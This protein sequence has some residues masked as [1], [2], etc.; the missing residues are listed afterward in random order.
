L[1]EAMYGEVVVEKDV[2]QKLECLAG[3]ME[4]I[5]G[6]EQHFIQQLRQ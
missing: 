2:R 3:Q 1:D 4:G 6:R 5:L